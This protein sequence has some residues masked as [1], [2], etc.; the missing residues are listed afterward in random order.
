MQDLWLAKQVMSAFMLPSGRLLAQKW[1][2]STAK[3]VLKLTLTLQL[4]L[5]CGALL[6]LLGPLLWMTVVSDTLMAAIGDIKRGLEV[7]Q[8]SYQGD[9]AA[10]MIMTA[11][12]SAAFHIA[13]VL[14][15]PVALCAILCFAAHAG[16][17]L[18]RGLKKV[19][20]DP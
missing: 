18:V 7:Q 1:Y 14:D 6:P 12:C 20:G 16:I 11:M 13:F 19:S 15:H 3:F 17:S 5:I 10:S 4:A 2:Q 9:A 8:M